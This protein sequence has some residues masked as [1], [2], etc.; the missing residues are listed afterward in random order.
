MTFS[1]LESVER[2]GIKAYVV[3]PLDPTGSILHGF[4]TRVGG[5]SRGPY[6][7]L[8]LGYRTGDDPSSVRENYRQLARAYGES[9]RPPILIQQVH[10]SEIVL[11]GQDTPASE[12]LSRTGDGLISEEPGASIGVLTSDC[13]PILIAD[14]EGRRVAALHAGWRG[15]AK[16]IAERAVA[17]LAELGSPPE[18][19]RAAL[20]P[21]IGG[22]CYEVGPEVI[23]AVSGPKPLREPVA[24]PSQR[25]PVRD[26]RMMLDLALANAEQLVA[27]G[28]PDA[29]IFRIPKCNACDSGEFFSY[30][31]DG[32]RVGRGLSFIQLS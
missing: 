20:G 12:A 24:R 1:I 29:S 17:R 26:G 14:P 6:A 2:N 30:R 7:T 3:P 13:L 16:R 25:S 23:E 8:N 18:R 10:S 9:F 32:E 28:I 4:L 15:T 21:A 31:R 5:V 27:S 19:L 22:C 11:V